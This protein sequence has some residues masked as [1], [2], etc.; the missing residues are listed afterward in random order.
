MPEE[1][2]ELLL[3]SSNV[4]RRYA[5]DILTALALPPGATIQFRYEDEYIAKSVDRSVEKGSLD[6][7][8]AVL[9]FIA[10]AESQTP[11]VVPVR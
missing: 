2:R 1:N 10:D 11:F 7:T 6:L 4:R 3:L 8:E 9:A 5:E